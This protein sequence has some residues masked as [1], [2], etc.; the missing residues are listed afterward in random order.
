MANTAAAKGSLILAIDA[1]GTYFK[2]ILVSMRGEVLTE[3]FFQ[4][5]SCSNGSRENII[6]AYRQ[7]ICKG[8]QYANSNGF[9]ICGI[10]ISTPGPFDYEQGMSLMQHKFQAIK[11]V[12]LR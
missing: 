12:P 2:S 5:S 9:F 3:S 8:L 6:G 4:A 11:N 10:G 1:G 7:V